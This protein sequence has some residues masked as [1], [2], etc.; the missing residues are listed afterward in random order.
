MKD[1]KRIKNIPEIRVS[2]SDNADSVSGSLD[3][4]IENKSLS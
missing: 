1:S 3:S 2:V 4:S